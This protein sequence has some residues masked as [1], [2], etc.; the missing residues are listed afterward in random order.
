[1]RAPGAAAALPSFGAVSPPTPQKKNRG[2]LPPPKKD[3]KSPS[4]EAPSCV[5]P[6]PAPHGLGGGGDGAGW[7][8][9]SGV[10]GGVSPE[11]GLT[12]PTVGAR[13]G[14]GGCPWGG[15]PPR[16]CPRG[17]FTHGRIPTGHTLTWGMPIRG[18]T[19]F[20]ISP[21]THP[22]GDAHGGDTHP[23][24]AHGG[25]A[26]HRGSARPKHRAGTCGG[27]GVCV[28]GR[29][30]RGGKRKRAGRAGWGGGGRKARRLRTCGGGAPAGRQ[31][32]FRG[33]EMADC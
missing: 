4:R 29:F 6:S 30:F 9:I 8:C 3:P 22:R 23:G 15:H 25:A 7:R 11:R 20:G 26:P 5:P 18:T 31:G 13:G 21:P 1:M 19:I 24:D 2:P 17:R 33:E 27:G 10:C 12:C 32:R 16:G 28:R 14:V